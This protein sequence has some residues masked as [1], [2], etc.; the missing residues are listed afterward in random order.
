MCLEFLYLGLVINMAAYTTENVSNDIIIAMP[1]KIIQVNNY[2]ALRPWSVY[3]SSL[4][5][6]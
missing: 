5:F 4:V 2:T 3:S 1:V 6:R